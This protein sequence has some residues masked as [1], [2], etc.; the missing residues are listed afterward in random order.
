VYDA[1]ELTAFFHGNPARWSS[2]RPALA[3]LS[4][5]QCELHSIVWAEG[6]PRSGVF[7]NPEETL[8]YVDK[9]MT[10]YAQYKQV[11]D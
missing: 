1:Q 6:R 10:T 11:L 7:D 9:V 2:V 4:S 5:G 8:A 3:L